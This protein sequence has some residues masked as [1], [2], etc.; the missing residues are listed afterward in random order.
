[1]FLRPGSVASS[2]GLL[3]GGAGGISRHHFQQF[4]RDF[5]K[6]R[7]RCFRAMS[8]SFPKP[9]F[10]DCR[11]AGHGHGIPSWSRMGFAKPRCLRRAGR[12]RNAARVGMPG[13]ARRM[14]ANKVLHF[15]DI[16]NASNRN[17]TRRGR[18]SPS[19]A[20]ASLA[21]V[22]QQPLFH[23]NKHPRG[24][25]GSSDVHPPRLYPVYPWCSE[26]LEAAW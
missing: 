21:F 3:A 12:G 17:V 25:R 15:N 24:A 2:P 20:P 19:E 14:R 6:F 10:Q 18:A 7:R 1:M 5:R 4:T 11:Y 22:G 8:A 9:Q 16:P 13:P 23:M 26:P